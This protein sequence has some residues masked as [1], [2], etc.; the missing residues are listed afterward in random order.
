[1]TMDWGTKLC[2]GERAPLL[3]IL[4]PDCL[5]RRFFSKLQLVSSIDNLNYSEPKKS[6]NDSSKNN[7]DRLLRK[8]MMLFGFYL[9]FTFSKLL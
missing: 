5:I 8:A 4:N 2:I 9:L 6:L 1:M 7:G 3:N